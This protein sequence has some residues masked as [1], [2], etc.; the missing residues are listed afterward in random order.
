MENKYKIK[1][2]FGK[3]VTGNFDEIITKV[4]AALKKEGFGVLSDIDVTTTLKA[5]IN[6][7]MPPYRILGACNPSLANNALKE[8]PSVGLLLPCNVVVRENSD[9]E[10]CIEILDPAIISNLTDNSHL[11]NVSTEAKAK[12]LRVIDLL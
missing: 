1:Y 9:G 5:K 8:E 4:T 3:T 2:G 11:A 7:D 10:I 12:L 6:V